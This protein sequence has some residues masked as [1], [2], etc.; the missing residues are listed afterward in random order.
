[1]VTTV[2][3]KYAIM[4]LRASNAFQNDANGPRTFPVLLF[5]R[6]SCS[7]SL[8]ALLASP[9]DTSST[10]VLQS[11]KAHVSCVFILLSTDARRLMI[12]ASNIFLSFL[13][14]SSRR[15][16]D[17]PFSCFP[18]PFS[19]YQFCAAVPILYFLRN[20]LLFYFTSLDF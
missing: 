11:R 2:M 20:I 18:P 16:W 15:G 6:Y 10:W 17:K 12:S 7:K 1:M 8:R 19:I 13:D 5:C 4:P 9:F 14:I 3:G